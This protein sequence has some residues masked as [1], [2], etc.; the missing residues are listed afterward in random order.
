MQQLKPEYPSTASHLSR[1]PHALFTPSK[2]LSKAR[3]GDALRSAQHLAE[4]Q[5]AALAVAHL[6]MTGQ[7]RP[8]GGRAE[9]PP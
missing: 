2:G 3:I 9:F 5:G 8:G 7:V 6:N 4:S 1:I